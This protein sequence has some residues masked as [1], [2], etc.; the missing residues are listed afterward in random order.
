MG[1]VEVIR[2]ADVIAAE[3]NGIKEQTRSIVIY[4]SIEIGRRLCEAKELV[5][6]GEWSKWLEEKVDYSKSTANNLMK[7]FK[8]YG[9]E[10]ISLVGS[11]I[12][13]EIYSKLNY[14]QAVELLGIPEEERRKFVKD[15][16]IEEMS[17]RKLKEEIKALKD[18]GRELE[19]EL[20]KVTDS[21]NNLEKQYKSSE[22]EKKNL[23]DVILNLQDQIEKHNQEVN[24]VVADLEERLKL[25]NNK[26][27]EL[28]ET[29]VEVNTELADEE[30]EKLEKQIKELEDKLEEAKEKKKGTESV[31]KFGVCVNLISDQ[32]NTMLDIIE[33]E[34][35]ET[36]KEK[37]SIAA[38][39]AIDM[40][41]NNL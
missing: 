4:N 25:A 15:N 26:I 12:K 5:E 30:R 36:V 35:D 41:K 33:S 32:F 40:M 7:I 23:S 31:T 13:D 28:Q 18:K 8:E 16:N 9:S 22:E 27:V 38:N 19:E 11:N 24:P 6:H 39:R 2:N 10:Q 34:K 20:N 14:S 21:K 37:L 17:T 29:P 3:I 1:T